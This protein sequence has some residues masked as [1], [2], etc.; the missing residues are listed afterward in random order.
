MRLKWSE[1][2]PRVTIDDRTIEVAEGTTIL[3]AARSLGIDIPTLCHMEGFDPD[4][5]CFVCVVQLEGR[6]ELSPSCVTVVADG[7]V[8]RTDSEDVLAARRTALELLL[9]DHTGD[10]EA[11]CS[12]ACPAHLDVADF[13][14][15]IKVGDDGRAIEII[16]RTIALPASLGRVCPRFCENACRRKE[17]DEAVA[18]CSLRRFAADADLASGDPCVPECADVSGKRAV[19]V[20][21]GPAGLSAAYYLQQMGHACTL[22][23][24][25]EQ[26]GGMFR[27]GIAEGRLPDEILDAEIAVIHGL[28][29]E[30]RTG[31]RLGGHVTFETLRADYDAVL[32]AMGCQVSGAV[33]EAFSPKGHTTSG[34]AIDTA[35]LE[36]MGLEVSPRG[37][38]VDRRTQA[39]NLPGVFAAGNVTSGPNYGVHAVAAGR[40]A[41]V[42]IDQHLRG[43]EVVGEGHHV[44]VLMRDLSEKELAAF[45]AGADPAPRVVL[46]EESGDAAPRGLTESEARNESR[47]CLD[48]DCAKRRHCDLR[49]TS[50]A[51]G[52]S[53]GRFRGER[54]PFSRDAT[55]PDVVYEA[56][57][58]IQCGRC[59]RIAESARETLGLTFV[60]RGFAVR[61]ATPLSGSLS[62]SLQQTARQCVEACP[63]GALS[64]K[65]GLRETS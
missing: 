62:A 13:I 39:T 3:A 20:G 10:C 22:L 63:T 27:Y 56:G 57:K 32:L 40:R 15:A 38:R 44:N 50:E 52:A 59:V 35:S 21:A 26:P 12:R 65:R 28:G 49:Q 16:R 51:V 54:R 6:R 45:H 36:Q 55:H 18:I 46:P 42:A 24:A 8:V 33:A 64:L 7:M 43:A 47:R 1:A 37:A 53:V 5:S 11:P 31:V 58:C 48:C 60:G 41:A 25:R 19:I 61:T 29:A 9:S 14:Q 4:P 34:G 17:L 23:E 30:I 2:M